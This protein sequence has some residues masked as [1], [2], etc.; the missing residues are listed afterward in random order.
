LLGAVPKGT[1]F[2]AQ[3]VQVSSAHD[4][5]NLVVDGRVEE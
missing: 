5:V 1:L 4:K 3:R 2:D